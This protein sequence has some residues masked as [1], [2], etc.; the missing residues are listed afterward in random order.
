MSKVFAL[1]LSLLAAQALGA[2]KRLTLIITG[3]MGGEI[4]PC[5]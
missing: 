2:E 3:D 1:G 5:G 4:A